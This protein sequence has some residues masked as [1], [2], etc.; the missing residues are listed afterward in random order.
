[1]NEVFFPLVSVIIPSYNSERFILDCL[2][3]IS[4]QSY[5][6]FECIIVNDGSTDNSLNIINE[7]IKEDSRFKVVNKI[8][9]GVG[10][11][12]KIGL[13][14]SLGQYIARIDADDVLTWDVSDEVEEYVIIIGPISRF[15]TKGNSVNLLEYQDQLST[16]V[17]SIRVLSQSGDRI[18]V[19]SRVEYIVQIKPPSNVT[20]SMDSS[21]TLEIKWDQVPG[22]NSYVV[23]FDDEFEIAQSSSTLSLRP[24][25]VLDNE[26]ILNATDV[27]IV[28]V[29]TAGNRSVPSGNAVF[30]ESILA[31]VIQPVS[32]RF[33]EI[34]WSQVRNATH[35]SI[36]I[37]NETIFTSRTKEGLFKFNLSPGL[38]T[39]E[40]KG[41]VLGVSSSPVATL[42]EFYGF[43]IS[44]PELPLRVCKR[45]DSSSTSRTY[46]IT[47]ITYDFNGNW[48]EFYFT[49][50]LIESASGPNTAV[51]GSISIRIL[52][53]EDFTVVSRGFSI[54]SLFPGEGFRNQNGT[55]YP[56]QSDSPYGK[57][58]L[59]II[60]IQ[61]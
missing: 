32:G 8:N 57:Y 2:R 12:L 46:E 26:V 18:S 61:N 47:S 1:M 36:T 59:D 38:T 17:V 35:Y 33:S 37:D 42:T 24:F 4:S 13:N 60:S 31:P 23:I 22:A 19:A 41:H 30:N 51:S 39:F 29:D 16:G 6:E 11:S 49:G 28:S 53:D 20:L 15:T 14:Q 25:Q 5:N 43:E 40:V 44:L 48:V 10:D 58:R 9:S 34:E 52:D 54:S 56:S 27:R 21:N 50:R 45:C 7:L 3:S 55:W